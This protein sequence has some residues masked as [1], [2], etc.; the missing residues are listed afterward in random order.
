[1]PEV[2]TGSKGYKQSMD[3]EIK[4]NKFLSSIDYSISYLFIYQDPTD[5]LSRKK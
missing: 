3:E 2:N 1:M 5:I 4:A